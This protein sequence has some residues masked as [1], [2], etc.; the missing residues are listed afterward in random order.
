MRIETIVGQGI[1]FVTNT[2]ALAVGNE[3]WVDTN[4][5]ARKTST[6][7][8]SNRNA[9]PWIVQNG[10][11]TRPPWFHAGPVGGIVAFYPAD[12]R[13]RIQTMISLGTTFGSTFIARDMITGA[14]QTPILS[15]DSND[16]PALSN[17]FE[18]FGKI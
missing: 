14:A 17:K 18:K 7:G 4:L 9:G 3:V 6:D 16:Y 5:S 8:G 2:N 11:W 1:L 10:L 15:A 12:S 13:W